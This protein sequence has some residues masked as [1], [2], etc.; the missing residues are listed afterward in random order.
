MK[1]FVFKFAVILL[2]SFSV[3]AQFYLPL[4]QDSSFS[5]NTYF[6]ESG[7]EYHSNSLPNSL[8]NK[9]IFG[10]QI[11]NEQLQNTFND[12]ASINRFAVQSFNEFRCFIGNKKL[13]KDSLSFGV[14]AGF[15]GHANTFFSK[16]AFGLAFF[17]NEQYLGNAANFSELSLN[18]AIFQ[19][20]GFGIFNKSSKSSFFLNLVNLQQYSKAY[21]RK[22]YLTQNSDAS[23]IDLKLQ[24]ELAFTPTNAFSTGIGFALDLDKRIAVQLQN[25]QKATIQIQVQNLG[26]AF[27]NDGLRSYE[28]DSTY[29]YSGF[30][31]NQLINANE[32]L[33]SNFSLMDSLGIKQR[34]TKSWVLLPAFIQVSKLIDGTSTKKIQTYYGIKLYPTIAAIPAGFLGLYWKI[35]SKTAL[36][37]SISYGAFGS[38][39]N[40][41]YFT[42]TGK[43]ISGSLGTDDALGFVSKK[44]FGQSL[45]LRF[46]WSI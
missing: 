15:Y 19:K 1:S 41:W 7:T 3:K 40:G 14:K 46:S 25:E 13:L 31:I 30:Q 45:F 22:A 42:F 17:G 26:L 4:T 6:I 32:F 44:A 27:V 10:G 9:F 24:G 43:K 36:A 29:N 16:D 12:Q 35:N 5:K 33:G 39:R 37:S 21:F 18:T 23:E 2:C 11:P 28:I 20:I 8:T 38:F 34:I